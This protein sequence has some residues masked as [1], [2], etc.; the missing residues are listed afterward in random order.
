MGWSPGML[1]V[2]KISNVWEVTGRKLHYEFGLF[3]I[4]D[5]LCQTPEPYPQN[6][7]FVK[8]VR[9]PDFLDE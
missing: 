7:S 2:H 6:I 1:H 5:L 9:N 4:C 3:G 8:V